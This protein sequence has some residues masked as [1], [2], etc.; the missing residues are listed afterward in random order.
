MTKKN[1]KNILALRF[2]NIAGDSAPMPES[3]G[4][5]Y[6]TFIVMPAELIQPAVPIVTTTLATWRCPVFSV[7]VYIGSATSKGFGKTEDNITAKNHV[8]KWNDD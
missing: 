2:F 4:F 1:K 3:E 5:R 7:Y 8:F 6:A